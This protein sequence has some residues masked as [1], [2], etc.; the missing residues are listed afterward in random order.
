MFHS[1]KTYTIKI[2]IAD[3]FLDSDHWAMF[4]YEKLMKRPELRQYLIQK[5]SSN[6]YNVVKRKESQDQEME[7]IAGAARIY[8]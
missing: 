3:L 5:A 7:K 1:G 8:I 6:D 4:K 2:D